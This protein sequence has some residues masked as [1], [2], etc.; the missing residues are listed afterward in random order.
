M[1]VR[2]QAGDGLL[3]HVSSFFPHSFPS[4]RVGSVRNELCHGWDAEEEDG[5][6]RTQ[7]L[8][9]GQTCR[10]A[11]SPPHFLL[12]GTQREEA[13]YKIKL[14]RIKEREREGKKR[15]KELRRWK[16]ALH[17]IALD[18]NMQKH[19]CIRVILLTWLRVFVNCSCPHLGSHILDALK[20]QEVWIRLGSS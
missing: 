14:Y 4:S 12:A 10:V 13:M 3:K 11:P 5:I 8:H 18:T 15:P 9:T 7:Q 20:Q 2:I 6:L 16:P 17:N 19:K 1:T